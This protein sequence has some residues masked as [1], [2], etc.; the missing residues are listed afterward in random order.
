MTQRTRWWII[1]SLAVAG[2]VIVLLLGFWAFILTRHQPL[3]VPTARSLPWPVVCTTRGCITTKQWADHVNAV[4]VFAQA[5]EANLA[6]DPR[7]SLTTLTRQHLAHAAHL[8]SPVTMTDARRYREEILNFTDEARLQAI[9]GMTLQ[10]YDALVVVPFLEQESLRQ[11][12]R[13][14]SIDD[15]YKQLAAE[16]LV[17][18][19]PW[20]L[21]WDAEQGII[22]QR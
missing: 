5:A 19:L 6:A 9:T 3:D 17:V 11:Q 8:R 22:T 14:E 18:A 16:R 7:H 15:L 20:H 10:E 21:Q 12:R 1:G 2:G 13:A 4:S